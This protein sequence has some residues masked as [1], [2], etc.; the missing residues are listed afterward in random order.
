MP[1]SVQLNRTDWGET[2]IDHSL[3]A[4]QCIWK[5]NDGRR[6]VKMTGQDLLW[7]LGLVYELAVQTST[8]EQWT[9]PHVVMNSFSNRQWD[10]IHFNWL[11][12][13]H[14]QS[15]C[16]PSITTAHIHKL[17]NCTKCYFKHIW[18]VLQRDTS[19]YCSWQTCT[20]AALRIWTMWECQ[21]IL[22]HL[23]SYVPRENSP[24]ICVT[25][26]K[27]G[28]TNQQDRQCMYNI[29]KRYISKND[30]RD[31]H[32]LINLLVNSRFSQFCELAQ[33]I[34][35]Y[36][37]VTLTNLDVPRCTLILHTTL[38]RSW[39]FHLHFLQTFQLA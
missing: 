6:C 23:N 22:S 12:I 2:K 32:F 34:S 28:L 13:R 10:G 1:H 35:I 18:L 20:L 25:S 37:D 17:P 26:I 19:G 11:S 38:F 31:P 5:R 3:S 15:V 8:R 21:S 36:Y 29:T 39:C 4:L 14:I 30:Q 27:T 33:N 16:Q 9:K 24:F 7:L